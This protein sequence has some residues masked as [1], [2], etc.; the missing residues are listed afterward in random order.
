MFEPSGFR[1][2]VFLSSEENI[3]FFFDSGVSDQDIVVA[4]DPNVVGSALGVVLHL[5]AK[6]LHDD[7]RSLVDSDDP[8]EILV[9]KFFGI[10]S[11]FPWQ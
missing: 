9:D 6:L 3:Q 7:F 10:F 4:V 8:E 2:G 1:W 5:K 11:P